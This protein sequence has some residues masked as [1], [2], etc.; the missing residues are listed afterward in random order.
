MW[1]NAAEHQAMLVFAEHRFYGQTWPCGGEEAAHED[2]LHLLTTEQA[3][4]DYVELLALIKSGTAAA[5]IAPCP[6]SPVIAFGGSYGGKFATSPPHHLTAV[7]RTKCCIF[8]QPSSRALR[9][10]T[11]HTHVLTR[12]RTLRDAC[13]VGPHEGKGK[14]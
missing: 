1:E 2:C 4:A 13:C 14:G 10:H 12:A 9:T 5:D 7:S 3:A 11:T 8:H 6:T